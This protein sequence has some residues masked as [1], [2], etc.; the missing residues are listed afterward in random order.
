MNTDKLTNGM[1]VKNYKELCILVEEEIKD[2]NSKKAQ[3]KDFERY[4]KYLIQ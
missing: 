2:G 1:V 4:Y 3:M